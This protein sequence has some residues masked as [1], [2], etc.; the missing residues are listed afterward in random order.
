MRELL[1]TEPKFNNALFVEVVSIDN[2]PEIKS[3][4]EKKTLPLSILYD[5][6][7]LEVWHME[8]KHDLDEVRRKLEAFIDSSE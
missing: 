5:F 6:E 8:G 1:R 7:E 3:K 4:Y 2:Y